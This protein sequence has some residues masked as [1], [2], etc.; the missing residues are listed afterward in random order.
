MDWIGVIR[1]L[2]NGGEKMSVMDYLK[3]EIK[4]DIEGLRGDHRR[5]SDKVAALPTRQEFNDRI[6]NIHKRID[7]KQDK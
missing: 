1:G 7:T 4:P 6:D 3:A 5:L 2:L